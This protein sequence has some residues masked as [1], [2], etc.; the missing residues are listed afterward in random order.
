[1]NE[2]HV[3][4]M[5]PKSFFIDQI[6]QDTHDTFSLKLKASNGSGPFSFRPGQFN[7]LYVFGIGEVPISISGDSQKATELIHTIRAVGGV[8]N[9]LS[10]LKKG[11]C[12]GLRGPFGSSWPVDKAEGKDVVII[13]GGIGLAPLRPVFYWLLTNRSKYGKVV[14]LYGARSPEDILYRKEL[15]KWRSQ[16]DLQV[17]LTVDQAKGQWLGTVG[18]V[19]TLIP[20]ARFEP[21]NTIAMICGPE[22]MIHFCVRELMKCGVTTKDIYISMERNMKCAVGFCGHCQLGPAFICKDGPVFNFEKI[23]DLFNKREL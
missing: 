15:E 23:K 2:T 19:T 3:D 9:A 5:I 6:R 7:M 10:K 18:V 20:K 4:P 14:L 16:F 11:Q 22:I 8:T 1:M 12:I 17:R 13:A 21:S